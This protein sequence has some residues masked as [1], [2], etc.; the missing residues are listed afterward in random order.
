MFDIHREWGNLLSKSRQQHCSLTN[1]FRSNSL[2]QTYPSIIS[3]PSHRPR[4][5][6]GE[7]HVLFIKEICCSWS[8]PLCRWDMLLGNERLVPS[9]Q[10]SKPSPVIKS[11]TRFLSPNSSEFSHWVNSL[12][13][14][15]SIRIVVWLYRG[16]RVSTAKGWRWLSL[17]SGSPGQWESI[18]QS[19]RYLLV[20]QTFFPLQNGR[21]DWR[22]PWLHSPKPGRLKSS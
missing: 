2:Q 13:R 6:L 22:F 10:P 11:F 18:I 17:A 1:T 15:K 7:E 14:N 21:Q 12:L 9:H 3:V 16:L 5:L 20:R 4:R 19:Y 8:R